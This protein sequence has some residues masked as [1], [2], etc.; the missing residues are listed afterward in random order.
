MTRPQMPKAEAKGSERKKLCERW[1]EEGGGLESVTDFYMAVNKLAPISNLSATL[2]CC[3]L[4]KAHSTPYTILS[5]CTDTLTRLGMPSPCILLG[6]CSLTTGSFVE[7]YTECDELRR[8]FMCCHWWAKEEIVY[9]SVKRMNST[10]FQRRLSPEQ[11]RPRVS[12]FLYRPIS[13]S[14]THYVVPKEP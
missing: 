10:H 14:S 5:P 2:S 12:S 8:M 7:F 6:C 13:P 11:V 1:E 9:Y 4:H 3:H